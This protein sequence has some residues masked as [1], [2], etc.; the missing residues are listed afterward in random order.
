MSVDRDKDR[1][2]FIRTTIYLPRYL[3]ESAKIMA[4][5]IRNSMSH[6]IR[7]ALAEKIK[8]LKKEKK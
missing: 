6:L 7:V 2:E 5:L 4:V 3:H 8:K 1:N